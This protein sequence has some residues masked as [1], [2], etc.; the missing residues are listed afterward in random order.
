RGRTIAVL[1][2]GIDVVY[3]PENRNLF[4]KIAESG[5][6]ITEF[7]FSTQPLAANFPARNRIISGLSLGVVVVEAG[8]K[9]GSLITARV[10]L[11]QG[12]EVFAVPGSIDSP[13]TKGT[14]KLIREGAKL[15][16]NTRDI[17]E[18]ILPQVDIKSAPVGPEDKV[19]VESCPGKSETLKADEQ[20]ILKILGKK[21][22]HVDTLVSDTGY[23]IQDILGIL[24]SLELKGYARQ[25]PGKKFVMKE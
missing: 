11:E 15:V 20:A 13:G 19:P 24:M 17:L 7:P 22:V 8:E 2:S 5:A 21:P 25:L 18:E 3:P 4:E 1:G 14:H 9:S 16:E 6:V 12:R 23:Q 10:A